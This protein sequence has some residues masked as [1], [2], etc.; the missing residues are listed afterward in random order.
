MD[1]KK[2]LESISEWFQSKSEYIGALF[3]FIFKVGTPITIFL[4]L[5]HYAGIY[6]AE[7]VME[8]CL[9]F[10]L[11]LC[12][13]VFFVFLALVFLLTGIVYIF[14]LIVKIFDFNNH[15]P[16]FDPHNPFD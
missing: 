9:G 1:L 6:G 2:K 5:N 11:V 3:S 8:F 10:G 4:L 15:L 12:V 14:M 7:R 13:I 16:D